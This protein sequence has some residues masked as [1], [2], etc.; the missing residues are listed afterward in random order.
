[1]LR[2]AREHMEG[3]QPA[4]AHHP[5]LDYTRIHSVGGVIP[6]DADWHTLVQN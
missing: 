4:M 3:K 1:M 5:E 2:A 6:A